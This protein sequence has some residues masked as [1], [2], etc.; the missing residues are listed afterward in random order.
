MKIILSL[1]PSAVTLVVL[2]FMTV[3]LGYY[4]SDRVDIEGNL[5]N[6]IKYGILSIFFIAGI[7][8]C[9]VLPAKVFIYFYKPRK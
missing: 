7:F 5:E 3:S 6:V 1:I 4:I 9:L 2:V 8:L